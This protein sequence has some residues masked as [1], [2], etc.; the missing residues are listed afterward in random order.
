MPIPPGFLQEDPLIRGQLQQ[1]QQQLS[2]L[3]RD[4]GES[5]Q[6]L[7]RECSLW[8]HLI[9][10]SSFLPSSF[11]QDA[12]AKLSCSILG[13]VGS[14]FPNPGKRGK[15][16]SCSELRT[17]FPGVIPKGHS[18]GPFQGLIPRAHSQGSFHPPGSICSSPVR[19]KA[20]PR[21]L[22]ADGSSQRIPP[23]F[24]LSAPPPWNSQGRLG[25]SSGIR[26]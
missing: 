8:I 7:L 22:G 3:P 21:R 1:F 2:H 4:P 25:K 20:L 26:F 14:F 19:I 5:S 6:C 15:L 18:Q 24:S 17:L 9:P 16:W 11:S 10:C 13:G 12:P 23:F